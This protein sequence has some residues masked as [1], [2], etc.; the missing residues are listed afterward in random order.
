MTN[1]EIYAT[2]ASI[3]FIGP[4]KG[5]FDRIFFYSNEHSSGLLF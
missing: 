5:V 3:L 2:T 4:I 1:M